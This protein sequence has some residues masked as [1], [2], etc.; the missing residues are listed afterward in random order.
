[1]N[2]QNNHNEDLYNFLHASACISLPELKKELEEAAVACGQE[3]ALQ[4]LSHKDSLQS[5]Q[6][7]CRK[8]AQC[9]ADEHRESVDET[10]TALRGEWIVQDSLL[11]DV[12]C[13]SD[14][15]EA[16]HDIAECWIHQH[17]AKDWYQRL[18]DRCDLWQSA[19]SRDWKISIAAAI[20][21]GIQGKDPEECQVVRDRRRLE[22]DSEK[23]C[24]AAHRK[25]ALW[26]RSEAAQPL[27]E[28][29]GHYRDREET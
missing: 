6:E 22:A 7:C 13:E 11:Y 9:L 1:M 27:I 17:T 10:D 16:G 14:L 29:N 24:R 4:V 12:D 5:F 23:Q 18:L 28:P 20:D 2:F 19:W 8:E 26:Y 3:E 15:W 25:L 21:A